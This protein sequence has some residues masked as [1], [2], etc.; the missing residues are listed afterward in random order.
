MNQLA[1]SNI[2][3]DFVTPPVITAEKLSF[4]LLSQLVYG[5]VLAIRIPNFYS[6][7]NCKILSDHLTKNN[8][9]LTKYDNAP[10]LN[11]YRFGLAY[12]E[13][14]FNSHLLDQYFQQANSHL[15][16][17]DELCQPAD[18]PLRAF[19][20]A[21]DEAWP[22]GAIPQSI[23]NRKMM[24]GLIRVLYE[25]QVFSP[26][27]DLLNRDIPQLPKR[28][29]PTTQLAINLYIENF[30]EGGELELWDYA[31]NDNEANTLYTGTHD[32][33]DRSKL[34]AVAATIKPQ[35]GE[36]ILFQSSKVHAVKAGTSGKRIA[37]SCFSAFRH[38]N[39]PLTYWI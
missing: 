22:K 18:N 17:M 32:F 30:P 3:D 16:K 13:T 6:T 35:A 21:L 20:E 34:P 26:H 1:Y 11:L 36:L 10:E 31:P 14:R 29:H 25:N 37:F 4:P 38:L 2:S 39:S 19:L 24:P 5:K 8:N 15:Q 12:F 23:N 33:Y 28:D 9:H 7:T 27:Q